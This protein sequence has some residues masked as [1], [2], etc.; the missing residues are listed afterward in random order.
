MLVRARL[1]TGD[2]F[3]GTL[4]IT[5]LLLG[6]AQLMS[7]LMTAEEIGLVFLIRLIAFAM[8]AAKMVRLGLAK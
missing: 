7:M 3:F 4:A 5:F 2:E 8:L 6:L 1:R